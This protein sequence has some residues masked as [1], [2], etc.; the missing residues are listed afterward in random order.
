MIVT[1][2][3]TAELAVHETSLKESERR[4]AQRVERLNAL[5]A[6]LREANK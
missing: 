3:L 6:K 4:H 5:V 1:D 2:R